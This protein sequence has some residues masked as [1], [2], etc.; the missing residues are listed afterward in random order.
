MKGKYW[1]IG[2]G[3]LRWN[4]LIYRK[5]M[6]K[7]LLFIFIVLK[8]LYVSGMEQSLLLQLPKDLQ[9][10]TIAKLSLKDI[11]TMAMVSRYFHELVNSDA[12]IKV[13]TAQEEDSMH[14]LCMLKIKKT[15]ELLSELLAKKNKK[16][17]NKSWFL[18]VQKGKIEVMQYFV[19]QK[20]IDIDEPN[21]HGSTALDW[22][23]LY[24]PNADAVRF[25][26]KNNADQN[27][28]TFTSVNT[29][30][31]K[32][33]EVHEDV[34]INEEKKKKYQEIRDLL[35]EDEHKKRYCG[36]HREAPWAP[37]GEGVKRHYNFY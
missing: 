5:N 18:A 15:K 14:A 37:H 27:K 26:L 22:C 8:T 30:L 7:K 23:A 12:A 3:R 13:F 36:G 34:E 4:L 16:E 28:S 25:L 31:L 29:T 20:L 35:Q 24:Y 19:K 1:R 32:T 21:K 2:Y 17:I 11:G 9:I 33:V 6:I 10:Q